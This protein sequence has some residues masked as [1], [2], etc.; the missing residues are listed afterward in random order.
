MTR[1]LFARNG[2]AAADGHARSGGLV[3]SVDVAQVQ[4]RLELPPPQ[5]R[6]VR[7]QLSAPERVLELGL[8]LEALP[9]QFC[10]GL[11]DDP[12]FQPASRV[13][14]N[15]LHVLLDRVEREQRPLCMGWT[16]SRDVAVQ[17]SVLLDEQ[18]GD[19]I[20]ALARMSV[21]LAGETHERA[22]TS[23]AGRKVSIARRSAPTNAVLPSAPRGLRGG[24]RAPGR[25]SGAP[26]ERGARVRVIEGPFS[27]TIGV[28]HE[29]DGKGKARVML[30]LLAVRIAVRDLAVWGDHRDRPVLSTSHR[31]RRP[32]RS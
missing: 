5:L 16:L 9:E 4:A 10:I 22:T 32:A 3:L 31:K 2:A 20:V 7:A 8:A 12:T 11:E 17:H 28:V 24:P 19:A 30:G 21:L 25:D 14:T 15:E 26:I 6:G 1:V 27:G 23:T 13:T 18:L 29:L